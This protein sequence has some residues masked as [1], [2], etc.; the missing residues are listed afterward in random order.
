MKRLLIVK[1]VTIFIIFFFLSGCATTIT[2]NYENKIKMSKAEAVQFLKYY[3]SN[4]NPLSVDENHLALIG[5]PYR[6]K[7]TQVSYYNKFT[8]HCYTDVVPVYIV[9]S[10]VAEMKIGRVMNLNMEGKFVN[11]FNSKGR[12]LCDWCFDIFLYDS[13]G[14]GDKF[15]S[16]LLAL[17]PNIK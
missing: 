17:C 9:F 7:T 14:P 12:A 11:L 15:I 16:A 2:Q 3:L 8:T 6:C 4:F 1:I 13:S 5:R 10:D